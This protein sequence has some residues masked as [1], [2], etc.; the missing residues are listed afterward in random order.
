MIKGKLLSSLTTVFL[1]IAMVFGVMP[2]VTPSAMARDLLSSLIFSINNA[3]LDAIAEGTDKVIVTGKLTNVGSNLDLSIPS[4]ITVEWRAVFSG[5]ACINIRGGNNSILD[6][7]EGGIIANTD[8]FERAIMNNSSIVYESIRAIDCNITI[9]G[10]AVSGMIF[11]RNV[12]VSG[13]S[14]DSG[15]GQSA[16]TATNSVA[17]S[18]GTVSV[19]KAV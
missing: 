1:T 5:A 8:G 9:S 6:I 16:I 11:A 10:G 18:A 19:N 15:R 14:V 2:L 17:I 3:G 13:G 12:T 7:A 4:G